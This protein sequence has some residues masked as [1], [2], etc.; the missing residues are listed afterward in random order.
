MYITI[1]EPS[2]LLNLTSE[3]EF[4][5]YVKDKIVI[6]AAG[7]LIF[8]ANQELLL[9]FRKGFWDLPKGKVDE[10]ESL[11]DCA[12]R[13]V[14]EETGLSNLKLVK[15]L[16]TTYHTY[17]LNG[18]SILKPSHWYLMEQLGT[19]QLVPQTEEDITAIGWF[20]K[21]KASLLLNEMYP[22]IRMLVEQYF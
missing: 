11:G 7:G 16:T 4:K 14:N 2:G 13:E 19:E 22:T 3:S 9:I 1:H 18:Q 15:F 5:D 20:N 17:N 10:G 8:N 6:E 21:E 12:L